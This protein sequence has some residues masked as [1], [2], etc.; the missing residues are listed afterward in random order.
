MMGPT[1]RDRLA[2]I[3]SS[4][5]DRDDFPPH[6]IAA[7]GPQQGNGV[8]SVRQFLE[9]LIRA[10]S[11]TNAYIVERPA[12]LEHP[13]N[14]FAQ[15]LSSPLV[16]QSGRQGLIETIARQVLCLQVVP[17]LLSQA[18]EFQDQTDKG[19][20]IRARMLVESG[21]DD[22]DAFTRWLHNPARHPGVADM[23]M[24]VLKSKLGRRTIRL[25]FMVGVANNGYR[26]WEPQMRASNDSGTTLARHMTHTASGDVSIDVMRYADDQ[27]LPVRAYEWCAELREA[28]SSET[29][30]AI[31]YGMAYAFEREDGLPAGGKW[32]LLT[33]ADRLADVDLLQVNA[34][35]EQHP[36]AEALIDVGDLAFVWLWE[37]RAGVRSG[38]GRAC[39]TAALADLRRRLHGIRTVVIDLKPYQ[40]V[41]SD[42]AAM[43]ATQQIEKLEAVDRL[44]TFVDGLHLGELVNGRCRYIVNRDDDDPNAAMRVMGLAAFEQQVPPGPGKG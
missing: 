14:T 3:Y 32:E 19:V 40:Y 10:S 8:T 35:F 37:R 11:A 20:Q 39:L 25:F 27:E 15:L 21:C 34:F 33:A 18:F 5:L 16:T 9:E 31:A 29:P 2:A 24:T 30:D 12:A 26:L 6:F 23:L 44:K 17:V 1:L 41:V 7:G 36:D 42:G 28:V 13:D 4:W 43:P 22:M 38:A